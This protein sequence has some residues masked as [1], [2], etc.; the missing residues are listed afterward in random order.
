MLGLRARWA[1]VARLR[2]RLR[3]VVTAPNVRSLALQ[4]TIAASLVL[5]AQDVFGGKLLELVKNNKLPLPI[6]LK[7]VAAVAAAAAIAALG[8]ATWMML[9]PP[10]RLRRVAHLAAPLALLGLIPPLCVTDAWPDELTSALAIAAVVLLAERLVRVSLEA[11]A[12]DPPL[13]AWTVVTRA[14]RWIPAV[15]RRW[16]P[17]AFVVASALG[18]A[19]YMSVFTLRMHGRFGTYGYDLGQYDNVFWTTLHGHPMRDAPLNLTED[20][21]ELR[22]HADLATLVFL[23]FY[24]I[25]PGAPALLVIQS[26][27]LG[28]GAIPLYRFAARHVGRATACILALAYLLYPPMHGLQF[29]DFHFQPIAA[30]FILLVID[31]VDDRRYWLCAV[32]FVVALGCRE[33]VAIGL[34]ILGT[35]V[36][37]SGYRPRAGMVMAVTA[38]AYFVVMRF[39]IMPRLGTTNFGVWTASYIYKD[40]EPEGSKDLGGVLATLV[41]NPGYVF[42]TLITADKLRYALQ[43]LLPVALLPIR[44]GYLAVSLVHGSILTVLTTRY[45]PTIDI[46]FQYAANFIPYIFPAAVLALKSYGDTPA[47]IVRKR[48]ALTAMVT[49]TVLCG[50]FWG[51]IPPRKIFKGGFDALPMTAP[52][53]ADRTREADLRELHAMVPPDAW[54][55][56][57][58]HE[59]PHISRVNMLSLRDTTDADYLLYSQGSG[60]FGSNNGNKAL[61]SGDFEK[62]AERP[63]L[64]LLKRKNPHGHG[65]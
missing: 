26:C 21:S 61:E 14:S 40:L 31:F 48:A 15:V 52:T 27:V 49:G 65:H 8:G 47:G 58:E 41:T 45:G 1:G 5:F 16:G 60:Y 34:A 63:G 57:S 51:A 38:T 2:A 62:M 11:A 36:A 64:V 25:K 55:A 54:L 24:A 59:M 7:L 39:V 17:V 19:I 9:A 22:N 37:L 10:A 4:A 35:F 18:Y 30:T 42:S 20:W 43:I 29:Y 23:P 33:D 50:V 53:D 12:A 6:R 28:L 44:R 3:E 56:V 32:A 13:R 46:G